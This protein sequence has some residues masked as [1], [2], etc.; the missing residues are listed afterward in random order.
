M[1]RKRSLSTR[2]PKAKDKQ[3]GKSPRPPP[4]T[5]DFIKNLH[6]CCKG[7]IPWSMLFTEDAKRKVSPN[8]GG[9]SKG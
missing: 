1:R 5:D 7:E 3:T 8:E 6:G 2:S 4:A 9:R